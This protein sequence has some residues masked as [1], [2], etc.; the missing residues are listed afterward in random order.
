[1]VVLWSIF[2]S[3]WSLTDHSRRRHAMDVKSTKPIISAEYHRPVKVAIAVQLSICLAS[4][5]MLDLGV[6]ARA[7]GYAM[8]ATWLGVGLIWMRRPFSPKPP[9][10]LFIKYG[11]LPVLILALIFAEL[12]ISL[13]G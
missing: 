6:F 10:L 8:L 2:F 13:M 3:K 5:F 1:M 11:F 12:K 7:C 4:L 9:D